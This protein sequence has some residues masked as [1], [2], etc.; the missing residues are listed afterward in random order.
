[1]VQASR[2]KFVPMLAFYIICGFV[3]I[4]FGNAVNK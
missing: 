4:M 1:M 3:G 2:I